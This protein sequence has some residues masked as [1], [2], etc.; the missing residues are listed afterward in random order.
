[1]ARHDRKILRQLGINT[2]GLSAAEIAKGAKIA[3]HLLW[4]PCNAGRPPNQAKAA[5]EWQ[6]FAR[7][8]RVEPAAMAAIKKT[9]GLE[10]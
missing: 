10:Q 7:N 1:M 5:A 2:R 4:E 9:L 8:R 6:A 3:S